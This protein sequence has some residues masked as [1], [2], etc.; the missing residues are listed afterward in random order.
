MKPRESENRKEVIL[1]LEAD[2]G[3][4]DFQMLLRLLARLGV[5]YT[6]VEDYRDLTRR[7]EAGQKITPIDTIVDRSQYLGKEH[8]LS[9]RQT[10]APGFPHQT[11][12]RLFHSVTDPR[13]LKFFPNL[14]VK[15]RQ[16]AELPLTLPD[17]YWGEKPTM[18][19]ILDRAVNVGSFLEFT[20][21]L[22]DAEHPVQRPHGLG[23]SS[24]N[25]LLGMAEHLNSRLTPPDR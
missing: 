25:F 6:L 20:S 18:T 8:F 17:E 14:D 16:E 4:E 24:Y 5:P 2:K 21:L 1:R 23:P 12:A 9:Y 15:N 22:S 11:A 3:S 19:E 13:T 7:Q 10:Y